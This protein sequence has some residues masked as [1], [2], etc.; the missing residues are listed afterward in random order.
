MLGIKRM[1]HICMAVWK[2]DDRLPML[3][4]L[5]GMRVAEHA[6]PYSPH[7]PS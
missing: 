1:D 2:L 6:A 3:T 4:E 5:F 7:L